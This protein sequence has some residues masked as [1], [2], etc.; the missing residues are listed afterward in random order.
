M[1]VK[2]DEVLRRGSRLGKYRI[3]SRLGDGAFAAV[4]R[5]S[6]TLE[7]VTVALK[8]PHSRVLTEEDEDSFRKEIRLAARLRHPHIL[9]LKSA[10]IIDGQY[11]LAYPL[12]EGTLAD[13]LQSRLSLSTGLEYAE[14]MTDAVAFAH[15]H[16]VIHC[17]IKPDNLILTRDG[18]MLTDFGIAKVALRTV[19]A[20]GSG[21]V[22]Y[23]APEQAMGK[24]SF[25]SDVF[26]LGLVIYRMFTGRLPEYPV[27]WPP[28]GYDRLRRLAHGDLIKLLRRAIQLDPRKRFTNADPMLAAL[29]RMKPYA[30]KRNTK[31]NGSKTSSRNGGDWK[32]VQWRQFQ[33]L[34]GKV[35][36]TRYACGRCG[37]PVSEPMT[38]CPWCAAGRATHKDETRMPLLC[39]RCNRGLKSDWS[40]CPWCYGPGFELSTDRQYGD[41]RYVAKCTNSACERKDLMPFMRYCPWCH[42]K[43]T[44]K[45][46]IEGSKEK[47]PSCSWG[48]VA[49]FWS[50]CPWCSKKLQK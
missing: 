14:Q 20:S 3:E 35:L 43:V 1:I 36:D 40:Y 4:Y 38:C 27:D 17:D 44:R 5:A 24:P 49:G 22:G 9:P 28:P 21:T 11:V 26:S 34:Y 45:W 23:C 19:R 12:G 33:R 50:C 30:L 10:D 18:L 13:R 42:R 39:P 7:G 41:A 48:V 8:I 31:R 46:K 2:R 25:R 6:D 15:Q 16:R 47:C 29:R 37:G 32:A